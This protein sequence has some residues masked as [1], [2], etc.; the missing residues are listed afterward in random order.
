[1]PTSEAGGIHARWLIGQVRYR[2]N[3]KVSNEDPNHMLR[4][5]KIESQGD[6]M[7]NLSG[8]SSVNIY[9]S[10]IYQTC[11]ENNHKYGIRQHLMHILKNDISVN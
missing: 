6:P 4:Q 9:S 11:F 7:P 10:K 5:Q 1:M 3:R 8:L 2:E